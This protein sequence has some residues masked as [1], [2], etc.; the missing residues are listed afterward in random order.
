MPRDTIELPAATLKA[1]SDARVLAGYLY[2]ATIACLKRGGSPQIVCPT[3]LVADIVRL[4]LGPRKLLNC[5]LK[6]PVN[7]PPNFLTKMEKKYPGLFKNQARGNVTV[8]PD[9]P[10]FEEYKEPAAL[11]R[12]ELA[13]VESEKQADAP[14]EVR[15]VVEIE[16]PAAEIEP[17]QPEILDP[18]DWDIY[19]DQVT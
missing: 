15:P 12:P 3:R 1:V 7:D 14:I 16:T 9:L 4:N 10:Q 5:D 8:A 19:M 13:E 11:F 17:T 2:S 6:F 18:D